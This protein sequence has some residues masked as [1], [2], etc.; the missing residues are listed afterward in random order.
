MS[1]HVNRVLLGCTIVLGT[2]KATE[3]SR[4]IVVDYVATRGDRLEIFSGPFHYTVVG[5]K[6]LTNGQKS[7]TSVETTRVV[8]FGNKLYNW[9]EVKTRRWRYGDTDEPS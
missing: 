6:T 4:R 3:I 8:M 9:S 5:N 7:I 2:L 1:S